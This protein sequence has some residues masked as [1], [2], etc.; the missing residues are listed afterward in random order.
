MLSRAVGCVERRHTGSA[1]QT[2]LLNELRMYFTSAH[3]NTPAG[4]PSA[5]EKAVG[6]MEHVVAISARVAA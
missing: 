3:A 5:A 4:Q 6:L 2:N 1:M